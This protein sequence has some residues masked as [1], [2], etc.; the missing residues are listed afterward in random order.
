MLAV[1]EKF[2]LPSAD[3]LLAPLVEARTAV[4]ALAAKAKE[5]VRHATHITHTRP[6]PAWLA[7]TRVDTAQCPSQLERW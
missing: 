3:S 4:Q 7:L 1:V 6:T 2:D 5:T